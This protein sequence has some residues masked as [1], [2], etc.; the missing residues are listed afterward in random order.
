MLETRTRSPPINAARTL[1]RPVR[2][3]ALQNVEHIPIAV[4]GA[5]EDDDLLNGLC[6]ELANSGVGVEQR[7]RSGLEALQDPSERRRPAR[8]GCA[9]SDDGQGVAIARLPSVPSGA[10]ST[11]PS[12]RTHALSNGYALSVS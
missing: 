4:V 7:L 3:S 9:V 1:T 10:L 11:R 8:S 12:V 5:V 6:A 2:S